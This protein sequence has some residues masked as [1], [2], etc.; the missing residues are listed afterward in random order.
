MTAMAGMSERRRYWLSLAALVVVL[1]AAIVVNSWDSLSEWRRS[2][3]QHAHRRRARR[4]A[5]L[6][7][8]R[9]GN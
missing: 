9:S 5:G 4:G 8:R 2:Q 3:L 1:P 7:R 6:C